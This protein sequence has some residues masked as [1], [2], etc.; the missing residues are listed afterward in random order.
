MS[1]TFASIDRESIR[2]DV[3]ERAL[4]QRLAADCVCEKI[5][6]KGIKYDYIVG[7]PYAALP[8]ATLVCDRLNAPM[9]LRRKEAKTYGTKKLIEG[10]YEPG[11]RALVVEDVVTSGSSI[12]ETCATLRR[13]GLICEAVVCVLDREQGGS[14]KLRK[15]GVEL[16]L[17]MSKILDYMVNTGMINVAQ[18]VDILGQLASPMHSWS[19][20]PNAK[21]W[22][23][24]VRCTTKKTCLCLAVD[25]T[26]CE[27]VLRTVEVAHDYVCAIKIHVDVLEDFS[28][29]FVQ[30]LT[31]AANFGDF[32]VFEDRKLSDTGNTV[33]LQVTKGIYEIA[34]WAQIITVHALPGQP[35]LSALR[36]V[37]H[38]DGTKLGG[39]LLVAELSTEGALTN[40]KEY[41]RDVIELAEANRDVVSGFICQKRCTNDPSFL[42]WTPGV[43]LDAASDGAGQQWRSVDEAIGEQGNDIIIVGR[44]ITNSAD[45]HTQMRRYRDAAWEALIK[46][47]H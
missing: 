16:V 5:R 21:E 15:D 4:L 24:A 37:V 27:D 47:N 46:R 28:K 9:L 30:K 33:E 45:I 12:L 39:C 13:R 22:S 1:C 38:R 11:G 34:S 41:L 3:I 31:A 20:A 2:S 25:H 17:T 10:N 40:S 18:K 14:T 32:I 43:N 36:K 6:S 44:A 7:V 19:T 42:Y 26:K 29:E 8:I 23:V 35:I